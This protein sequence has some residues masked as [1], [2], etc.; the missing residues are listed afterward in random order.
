MK[1]IRLILLIFCS[2]SCLSAGYGQTPPSVDRISPTLGPVGQWVYVTGKQFISNQTTVSVGGKTSI[3]AHVY[4]TT[5]LGFRIPDGA[6]GT[7]VVTVYTPYGSASSNQ[8]YTVGVPTGPPTATGISPLLGPIGQ[9]VY[10][11]GTNFVNGNTTITFSGISGIASTVY[12]PTSLGFTIP[13]GAL[14]T[15]TITVTTPNGS[16]TTLQQFTVGIPD[17]PPLF[18][19]LREYEGFNWVYMTGINFVNGQTTIR[20]D[21]S[22]S[23][24]ATVYS[25]T[26]LGFTP[27]SSWRDSKAIRIT[28]PNGEYAAELNKVIELSFIANSAEVYQIQYSTDLKT[29]LDIGTPFDG[30]NAAFRMLATFGQ[31]PAEFY[32]VKKTKQ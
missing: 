29:W 4:A 14:G 31:K 8:T 27:T 16:A 1:S 20:L 22:Y 24:S 7:T 12:S 9:W 10:V 13:S 28:T 6:V 23:T 26:S 19:Q 15:K 32:R 17:G 5:Q 2:F 18:T 11:T 30:E 21:D 25:P 3:P